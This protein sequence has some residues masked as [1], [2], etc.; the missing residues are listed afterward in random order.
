MRAKRGP[1]V[2][3]TH[4][5][6][7]STSRNAE[8]AHTSAS[9][10]LRT[11][12]SARAR[13]AQNRRAALENEHAARSREAGVPAGNRPL[14]RDIAL[15]ELIEHIDARGVQAAHEEESAEDRGRADR[16]VDVGV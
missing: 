14:R 15:V 13:L 1:D 9:R 8:S 3:E 16:R 11:A 12:F 10:R 4:S 7:G 2:S 5:A 6:S